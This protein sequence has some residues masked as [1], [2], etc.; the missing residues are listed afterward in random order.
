MSPITQKDLA[1]GTLLGM[2][3]DRCLVM[4][5]TG[6][7]AIVMVDNKGEITNVR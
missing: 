3:A 4:V 1:V 7:I 6:F 5:S 2:L